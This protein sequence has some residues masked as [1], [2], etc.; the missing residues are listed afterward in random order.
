MRRVLV[1]AL[2]AAASLALPS[3]FVH[4]QD[5]HVKVDPYGPGGTASATD[6]TTIQQALDHAPE[7]PPRGRVIIMIAPGT[8]H[9]RINV[10]RNRP[11]VTLIGLGKTPEETVITA[12]QNAKSAGGTFFTA[13]AEIDGDAFEADN[14]TFEN[15]AGNTGQAVAAAVRSDRAVFKHVWFIGDQDTLFAD[16]GRQYYVNSYIA[17]GVDFIFGNAAAVFDHSEIHILRP[18]YLTAQSRVNL[19]QN[20]GYVITNSRVTTGIPPCPEGESCGT[21]G[22]FYLGRP[23]RQYSRVIILNTE[24][25]PTLNPEG[26]SLWKKDDP[27]PMAFYAEFHNTGPGAS[28]ATRA[29]WSHQLSPRDALA[30]TPQAFLGGPPSGPDHWDPIFEAARLP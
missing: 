3:R 19:S 10:T 11:R 27:T 21:R 22:S 16:M 7:P 4:A 17:G 2:L 14:L 15:T 28:P 13:T 5:I 1:L 30:Y 8:Y 29:P 23:W 9:E 20:T 12:S 25:P 18:G 6:Y 24:L 26:W